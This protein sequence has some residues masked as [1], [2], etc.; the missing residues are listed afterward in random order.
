VRSKRRDRDSDSHATGRTVGEATNEAAPSLQSLIST[1]SFNFTARQTSSSHPNTI[2]KKRSTASALANALSF[3]RKAL[4]QL[5]DRDENYL[6]FTTTVCTTKTR[7]IY[8]LELGIAYLID[9]ECRDSCESNSH[10]PALPWFTTLAIYAILCGQKRRAHFLSWILLFLISSFPRSSTL[11]GSSLSPGIYDV[12]ALCWNLQ[13][14]V[15]QAV[16]SILYIWW[17]QPPVKS[18]MDSPRPSHTHPRSLLALPRV[19]V[20]SFSSQASQ[21]EST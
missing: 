5:E 8:L 10:T 20:S 21:R 4:Q 7:N 19:V 13:I 15:A 9:V 1:I 11:L 3:P 12:L 18:D 16:M 14:S 17:V 6:A 2:G